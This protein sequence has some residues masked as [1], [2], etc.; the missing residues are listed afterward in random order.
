MSR[1]QGP[2]GAGRP[3]TRPLARWLRHQDPL[4]DRL[5]GFAARLPPHRRRGERQSPVRNAARHRARHHAEGGDDRQGIGRWGKPRCGTTARH[6]PRHP[7]S[8]QREGSPSLLPQGPLPVASPQAIGKLK[9]FKRIAL[10][11]EKTAENYAALLAF[12][13][14]IILVKSV[15]T[16][17]ARELQL[18]KGLRFKATPGSYC[19]SSLM[20]GAQLLTASL[21]GSDPG[22][23][24]PARCARLLPW[25]GA[26]DDR[27][28]R[29]APPAARHGVHAGATAGYPSALMPSC[30]TNAT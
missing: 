4:E 29:R 19:L 30:W 25:H 15:H 7:A 18:P 27:P 17:Y 6:L 11:C 24:G 2:K 22:F 26:G 23:H 28:A 20:V 21:G 9:R 5:R 10:R 3:G 12:A 13:C 1:P 16:A 8:A 14:G